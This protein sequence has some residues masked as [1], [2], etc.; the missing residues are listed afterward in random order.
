MENRPAMIKQSSL[1][2]NNNYNPFG[3]VLKKVIPK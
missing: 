1:K 3:V 2:G